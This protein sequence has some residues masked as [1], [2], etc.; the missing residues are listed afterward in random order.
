MGQ[1]LS[2]EPGRVWGAS[3]LASG[4]H[5]YTGCRQG[6]GPSQPSLPFTSLL[7]GAPGFLQPPPLTRTPDIWGLD[8]PSLRGF[9]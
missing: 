9:L 6:L 2:G 1:R 5:G 3:S 8:P 4:P 7:P